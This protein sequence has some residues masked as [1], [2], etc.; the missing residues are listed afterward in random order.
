MTSAELNKVKQ[1]L[2]S[3]INQ[4]SDVEL[5]P[6]PDGSKIPGMKTTGGINY[7]AW[8]VLKMVV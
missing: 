1:D 5:I 4:L 2:I 3:W 6:F 7:P 8:K